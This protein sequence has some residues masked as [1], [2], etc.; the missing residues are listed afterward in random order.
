LESLIDWLRFAVLFLNE[1]A[2]HPFGFF[3]LY[4]AGK[5][6]ASSVLAVLLS[7][8][9]LKLFD[10]TFA[11]SLS[12]YDA[13]TVFTSRFGRAVT[14]ASWVAKKEWF[15]KGRQDVLAFDTRKGLSR[16]TIGLCWVSTVLVVLYVLDIVGILFSKFFGWI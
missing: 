16:T 1:M 15:A 4:F 7:F 8:R 5:A 11:P 10:P 12:H 3:L 14:Y 6:I 13:V 9:L 2:K